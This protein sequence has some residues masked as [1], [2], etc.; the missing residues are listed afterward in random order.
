MLTEIAAFLEEDL[1]DGHNI[2]LLETVRQNVV[3]P[4]MVI[5]DAPS[6]LLAFILVCGTNPLIRHARVP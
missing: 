2:R 5:A 1:P 6:K 3:S 4:L